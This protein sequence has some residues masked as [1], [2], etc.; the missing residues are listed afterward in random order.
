MV[1]PDT[2]VP[3]IGAYLDLSM[4]A[5]E[6]GAERTS[7]QWHHLL[8][9]AGF[10]IERIWPAGLGSIIEAELVAKLRGNASSL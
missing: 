1:L 7:K 6:T 5:L 10:R 9:T 3:P 4:M 8:E 2:G